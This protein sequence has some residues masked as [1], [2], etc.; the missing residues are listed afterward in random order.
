ML[1]LTKCSNNNLLLKHISYSSQF[2]VLHSQ[3]LNFYSV[4]HSFNCKHTD[5]LLSLS[6][7]IPSISKKQYIYLICLFC[8]MLLK[9]ESAISLKTQPN[10]DVH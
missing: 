8:Q 4:C 3:E 10:N 6:T 7:L 2:F 9:C 5:N 1:F